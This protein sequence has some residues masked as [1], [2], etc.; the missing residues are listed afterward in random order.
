MISPNQGLYILK[1]FIFIYIK[2]LK[3]KLQNLISYVLQNM[4]Y[5]SRIIF[6]KNFIF[7]C[8]FLKNNMIKKI[9]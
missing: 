2:F 3:A 5:K 4:R 9:L 8:T 1:I 6:Q 7:N